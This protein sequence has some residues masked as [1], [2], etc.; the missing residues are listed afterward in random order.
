MLSKQKKPKQILTLGGGAFSMEPDNGI[1]DKYI[2]NLAL[3]KEPR[4]CF[5]GTASDDGIEYRGKFYDFYEKQQCKPFHLEFQKPPADIE[6]FIMSMHI[7]HVGGGSTRK[8]I[9]TWKKYG[10]DKIIKKAYENGVIM[11]GMSA[12]AI[13][14]F[15]D[16]IFHDKDDKLKRLPC[17]GL[18]KGSFCPHYDNEGTNLR[19]T[20][21]KLI[22]DGIIKGGYGVDD[23]AA[24][25]F[26][27][28]E[29]IRVVSSRYGVK[30]IEVR[31]S[32]KTVTEKDIPA[33]YLG[34]EAMA[35]KETENIKTTL[36]TV[37]AINNFIGMI[38]HHDLD[39]IVKY[40]T[41]DHHF[42]DSIG[43]DIS[44]TTNLRDAWGSLFSLFPDYKIEIKEI[45]VEGNEAVIFGK[46][47]GSFNFD[48]RKTSGSKNLP[49]SWEVPSAWKVRVIDDKIEEWRV[50]TDMEPLRE[51]RRREEKSKESFPFR[52]QG[53]KIEKN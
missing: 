22:Q 47:T 4:I 46:I 37:T 20:Y 12:G 18:L 52:I 39:S 8:I 14:W 41:P 31:K 30:A 40:V 23:G 35:K 45:L 3:V 26:V 38:N 1:L 36:N 28:G 21:M 19:K 32:G 50:Y 10:A 16:G 11:T 53:E 33:I 2:L 44:G 15:E 17:L 43:V 49:S 34:D 42:Y 27:D 6:D 48:E 9:D 5:L 51:A 24:L 7:L 13:C 25:H 29:L